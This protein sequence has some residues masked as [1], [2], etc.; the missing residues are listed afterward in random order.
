[1]DHITLWLQ[2]SISAILII[3]AGYKLTK[4]GDIISEKFNLGHAFIGAVLIGWSTSLPELVLSIGTTAYSKAPNISMGNVLGSNLFNIL[5]I[6]LLDIYYWKGSILR[7]VNK[8]LNLTVWLSLLMVL[9]TGGA[10]YFH[11]IRQIPFLKMGYDSCIIFVIYM[12]C[13]YLIY[14]NSNEQEEEDDAHLP[15]KYY[16]EKD[17]NLDVSLSVLMVKTLIVIAMIVAAGLWL[18]H[19][20]PQLSA[21][22]KLKG[23]FIGSFFLAIV[24]SLPEVITCFITVKMGFHNMAVG[25]L[26]GSNIFN[27]AIIA[28]CDVFYRDGNIFHAIY[29]ESNL[30]H[31]SSVVIIVIMTLIT[32]SILKFCKKTKKGMFI[33]VE[34]ILIAILY[35]IAIYVIYDPSILKPILG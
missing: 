11:S 35:F 2:F 23:G 22:Y 30:T 25:T 1:M 10:L 18:S 8:K 13:M 28:F 33:G 21:K 24:S 27:M 5:I 19:L 12:I 15:H 6:V 9:L 29:N 34:S 17:K 4:Y 32:I 31:L 7:S 3:I 14:K 16:E 26:F 20:A